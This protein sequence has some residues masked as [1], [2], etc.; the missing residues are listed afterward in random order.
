MAAPRTMAPLPRG[1]RAGDSSRSRGTSPRSSHA[2]ARP[3]REPNLGEDRAHTADAGM[4]GGGRSPGLGVRPAPRGDAG[5]FALLPSGRAGSSW[6]SRDQDA[7][8]PLSCPCP[9]PQALSCSLRPVKVT[10][11]GSSCALTGAPY[12]KRRPRPRSLC[13]LVKGREGIPRAGTPRRRR[14]MPRVL[15]RAWPLPVTS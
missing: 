9:Q 1:L 12:A 8:P 3:G 4:L 2:P 6:G 11:P 10:V 7:Q 15:P 5:G 14:G 13:A